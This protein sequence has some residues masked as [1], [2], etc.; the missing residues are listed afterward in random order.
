[1]PKKTQSEQIVA[2]GR[3]RTATARARLIPSKSGEVIVNNQPFEKYFSGPVAQA[4]STELFK[5]ANAQGRFTVTVKTDG[6]GKQGQLGA[7][8]LAIARAF[9]Q[10][11]PKL[12]PSLRKKGFMTRDPRA[13]QR[14]KFG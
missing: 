9:C 2:V 13:R 6:S 14:E 12:K 10:F 1:M 11:D 3:R 5:T 4:L 8:L 7:T